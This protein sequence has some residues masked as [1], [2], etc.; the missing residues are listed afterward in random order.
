MGPPAFNQAKAEV[1]QSN[2]MRFTCAAKRRQVQARVGLP[3]VKTGSP[4][5]G[6]SHAPHVAVIL[7]HGFT[8]PH[9]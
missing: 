8:V 1:G 5:S 6:P 9:S 4:L 7:E 3:C 2:E